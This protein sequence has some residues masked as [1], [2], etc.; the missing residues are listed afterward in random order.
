MNMIYLRVE[1]YQIPNLLSV[2]YQIVQY[3]LVPGEQGIRI[4]ERHITVRH[5]LFGNIRLQIFVERGFEFKSIVLCSTAGRA[6]PWI[7]LWDTH[8]PRDHIIAEI[9]DPANVAP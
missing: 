8:V 1:S 9:P 7:G 5:Q 2:A 3:S 6:I 4:R